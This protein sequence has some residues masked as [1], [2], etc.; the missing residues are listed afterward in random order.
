MEYYEIEMVKY[1]IPSRIKHRL[2]LLKYSNSRTA[3]PHQRTRK[4]RNSTMSVQRSCARTPVQRVGTLDDTS[5][6]KYADGLSRGRCTR[7]LRVYSG[8]T[9]SRRV[10]AGLYNLSPSQIPPTSV[11]FASLSRLQP[12]SRSQ[13]ADTLPNTDL[14]N[15]DP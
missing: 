14:I 11:P 1:D 15:R 3:N 9:S 10:F 7:P 2:L 6:R 13:S 5:R 8:I 4:I 12:I